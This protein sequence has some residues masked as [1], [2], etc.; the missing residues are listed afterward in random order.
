MAR[1]VRPQTESVR[2]MPIT[3]G[4]DDDPDPADAR[5]RTLPGP[6]H[7]SGTPSG[8]AELTV[9]SREDHVRPERSD[10]VRAGKS[11]G[12]MDSIVAPQTV[13][14]RRDVRTLDQLVS[15]GHPPEVRPLAEELPM[16][17]P[18]VEPRQPSG[19]VA[20]ASAVP[21]RCSARALVLPSR[22]P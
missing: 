15:D 17:A 9:E 1:T 13:V 8:F 5:G 12:E 3:D 20:I 18:R 19:D 4:D 7:E 11:G 14:P 16:R 21:S 6:R 22:V 2:S 10:H